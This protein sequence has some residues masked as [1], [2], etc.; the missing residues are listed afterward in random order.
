MKNSPIKS[1]DARW[2]SGAA[3]DSPI[4]MHL[5]AS[6]AILL[7]GLCAGCNE[8]TA[9]PT[10]RYDRAIA[11]PL[12][13]GASTDEVMSEPNPV[14]LVTVGLPD[15][16]ED[17]YTVHTI[18]DDLHGENSLTP[19]TQPATRPASAETALTPVSAIQFRVVQ[20]SNP[21]DQFAI[22]TDNEGNARLLITSAAGTGTVQ[23]QRTN[24]L[25]PAIIHVGLQ[26][27]YQKTFTQ[28]DNFTA[29]ETPAP[30]QRVPLK[31]TPL[32]K[33]RVDIKIPAFSRTP[34]ITLTW[35]DK[36]P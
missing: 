30:D 10:H 34:T 8:F 32:S 26:Y 29:A 7:V 28:L 20:Q 4:R 31:T 1:I 36:N 3:I 21:D 27:A 11:S 24:D 14:P 35:T 23:L 16:K 6:V 33:D 15:K 18:L 5:C 2:R 13:P 22:S 19:A 17:P 12:G 9:E 25:W